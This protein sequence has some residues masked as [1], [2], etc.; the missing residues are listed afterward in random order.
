MSRRISHTVK[1]TVFKNNYIKLRDGFK[2]SGF[3][4]IAYLYSNGVINADTRDTKDFEMVLAAVETKLCFSENTWDILMKGM[5]E[6][7]LDVLSSFLQDELIL[8][9]GKPYTSP[10]PLLSPDCAPSISRKPFTSDISPALPGPSNRGEGLATRDYSEQSLSSSN[11]DHSPSDVTRRDFPTTLPLSSRESKITV[12]DS[13]C[14]LTAFEDQ[15]YPNRHFSPTQ[16]RKQLTPI[17]RSSTN[18]SGYDPMISSLNHNPTKSPTVPLPPVPASSNAPQDGENPKS[19]LVN[20]IKS[21]NLKQGTNTTDNAPQSDN[22]WTLQMKI[23]NLE[24]E[25]SHLRHTRQCVMDQLKDLEDEKEYLTE[26]RKDDQQLLEYKMSQVAQENEI[27]GRKQEFIRRLETENRKLKS[28]LKSAMEVQQ[29]LLQDCGD[30]Q[31]RLQLAEH[32]TSVS[33]VSIDNLHQEIASRDNLIKELR[34]ELSQ[35][36]EWY[37]AMYGISANTSLEY[38]T[39]SRPET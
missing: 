39:L 4:I 2:S 1:C 12:D 26:A 23:A 30:L 28:D 9:C 20:P 15:D 25:N 3:Q 36:R 35:W 11:S 34:Q 27:L 7:P 29:K 14:D 13:G 16:Y 19:E 33:A 8:K 5:T 6:P 31:S 10:F 22:G 38:M 24:I 37:E 32:N 17:R 18:D 21:L